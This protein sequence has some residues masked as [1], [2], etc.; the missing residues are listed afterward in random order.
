[1][2]TDTGDALI[3]WAQ[4]TAGGFADLVKGYTDPSAQ[5]DVLLEATREVE[6][7]C[8]R[9]L[10]PFTITGESHRAEG[11]DP[12]EYTDAAN[13]PM[14]VRSTIG[15]SYAGALGA[16]TLV[17]STWLNE[18]APRYAEFWSYSNVSVTLVRSYGGTQ[19][20]AA[21]QILSGP[22]PDSGRLWFQLGMFLP[23]ASMIY[24]SYSGGYATVPADLSRATK[25]VAAAIVA[26]EL[27]PGGEEF[28]AHPDALRMRA[29][30]RLFAY[31]RS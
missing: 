19:D 27:D 24:V 13:L 3:T 23:I 17:R 6:G 15:A 25:Y 21:S 18:F 4:L 26:D 5:A 20:V 29:E 12:D 28:G 30:E 7:I 10:A 8:Q 11:I 14:D 16:S 22:D 9:R 2:S 1:M 31:M